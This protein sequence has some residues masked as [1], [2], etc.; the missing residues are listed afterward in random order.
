MKLVFVSN[1]FNHHQQPVSDRF[2]EL[3]RKQGG[4]Y[5]FVQ[6]EQMEEERLK[7]GWGDVFQQTSY[8][9]NYREDPA[10]VQRL[11]DEADAVIFGGTDEECYISNRLRSGK[12]IIRYSER[13]YKTGR[14]KFVS[15]RGLIKKFHDHTRYG[16]SKVY[17]L[18]SGAYV[19]GDFRLVL[20]YPFKKIKYGYFP[21][22]KEY[23]VDQLMSSKVSA[24]NGVTELMWAARMIDWKHPEVPIKLASMLKQKGYAFHLTM[25]G[26]GVLEEEMHGLAEMLDVKECIS[27]MGNQNPERVRALME[28]A[29]IYLATSDY[30]E[31]WGAVINEAMNSGCA[32]VA[33]KGMG[34]APYLIEHGRNGYMYPNGKIT[35]A[36]RCLEELVTDSQKRKKIGEAAY[37]TIAQEW[38]ARIAADRTYKL[39]EELL[40]GRKRIRYKTGPLSKA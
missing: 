18:C 10:G 13:L 12:L 26:G 38:N 30:Q 8:L 32:I 40:A 25:V 20:A 3:C 35:E 33:N 16:L 39:I 2:D 22:H 4:S 11:I 24:Q 23:D 6:T 27:F 29:D 14:Y 19:A 21:V 36:F 1:Y 31:G 17:L 28:K 9:K 15:P 34:A 5:T 37:H 7:M